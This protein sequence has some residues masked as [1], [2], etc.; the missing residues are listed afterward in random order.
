MTV[1]DIPDG[2]ASNMPAGPPTGLTTRLRPR[3]R[4]PDLSFSLTDGTPWRLRDRS[5]RTFTML[6]V[7]RHRHCGVCRSYIGALAGLLPRF[8][9][10]GVAPVA[11][12]T[13][14]REDARAVVADWGLGDLPVGH[15][16]PFAA[17]G[18]WG[19]YLSSGRRDTDPDRFFEPALFLIDAGG[20]LY[21]ASIQS[22]PFGRTPLAD[23]LDW[24][25]K[26][27]DGNIP[28]R[29]ELAVPGA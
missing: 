25:P 29:G 9:A 16:L 8:H 27:V 18:P 7:Y 2:P 5:P 19:L 21:Y 22:M 14:G 4:V 17:G 10:L 3:Q 26:L 15:G 11:V 23:I 13:D 20:C 1:Q 28:A 24:V 12:S 6:V